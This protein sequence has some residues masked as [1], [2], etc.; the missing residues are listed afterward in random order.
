MDGNYEFENTKN[1]ALMNSSA[2][3][4]SK[5]DF[6]WVIFKTVPDYYCPACISGLTHTKVNSSVGTSRR[7]TLRCKMHWDFSVV[8]RQIIVRLQYAGWWVVQSS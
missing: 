2:K 6:F 4:D 1:V 7:L 8:H 3:I 5:L